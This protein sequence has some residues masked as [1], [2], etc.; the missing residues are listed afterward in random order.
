M[1]KSAL[2]GAAALLLS[3]QASADY[4]STVTG[5]DMTGVE[6]TVTFA[7]L[8]SETL[9]WDTLTSDPSV[10]YMEGYSGGVFGSGWSL[11]QQGDTISNVSPAGDVLGAWTFSFDGS[12]SIAS[13]FIDA[14][15]ADFVFDTEAGDASGN[16]SGAG[17][18]FVDDG[19][20]DLSAMFDMNIEDELFGTLMISEATGAVWD[21]AGSFDFAIDTDM[22]AV[23]APATI[24][25]FAATLGL[26]GFNRRKK[27]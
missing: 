24:G 1:K 22:V 6:V 23:P 27:A 5:A 13:V 2:L 16:G 4:I 10:P 11:T 12:M 7:D 20:Y 26:M 19:T 15:V 9:V 21:T 8:S 17:R 14:Y 25:I 3:G 18:E